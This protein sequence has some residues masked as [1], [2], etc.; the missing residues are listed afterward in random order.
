VQSNVAAGVT[1]HFSVDEIANRPTWWQVWMNGSPIS[2]PIHLP[3]SNHAWYPQVV[4][5][6]W[7]GGTGACNSYS[8]SFSDVALATRDDGVWEP[9]RESFQFQDPGY[10]IVPVATPAPAF[11]AESLSA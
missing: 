3:G 6:N 4:G 10:R 5:E 11:L 7:N 8:Y 9:L 1:D 2:P